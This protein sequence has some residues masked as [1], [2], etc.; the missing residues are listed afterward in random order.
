M[1]K[2]NYI[3]RKDGWHITL[4]NGFILLGCML[5]NL[6]QKNYVPVLI[7]APLSLLM[8]ILAYMA[9]KYGK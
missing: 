1:I 5:G 7:L 9:H 6:I 3:F 2:R 4:N 8:F